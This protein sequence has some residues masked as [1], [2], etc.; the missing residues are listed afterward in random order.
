[1]NVFY[2]VIDR[3]KTIEIVK[4]NNF[5]KNLIL[6]STELKEKVKLEHENVRQLNF[7]LT[8]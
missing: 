3:W 2:K 1:M 7:K 5:S 4:T 8:N 6:R